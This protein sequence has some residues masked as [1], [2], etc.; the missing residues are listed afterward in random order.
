M[1]QGVRRWWNRVRSLAVIVCIVLFSMNAAYAQ[2]A[3]TYSIQGTE[4]EFLKW[5]LTQGGLTVVVLILFWSYRRDTGRLL[6]EAHERNLAVREALHEAT[7]AMAA[8]TEASRQQ[9]QAFGQ[10]AQTVQLCD[11]VRRMIQDAVAD[12]GK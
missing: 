12:S 11:A 9:I 1:S 3:T 6:V 7:A 2:A 8:H 4:S 5:A 10:L